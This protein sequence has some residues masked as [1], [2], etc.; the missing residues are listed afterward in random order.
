MS[1]TPQGPGW[2]QAS[3]GN[4]YPPGLAPGAAPAPEPSSPEAAATTPTSA[5]QSAPPPSTPAE[6]Q[7]V[8]SQLAMGGGGPRARRAPDAAEITVLVGAGV[9]LLAS[10]LAFYEV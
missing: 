3:D 6:A 2:W 10:F 5:P 1:T 9:V 8:G 7:P 4:W